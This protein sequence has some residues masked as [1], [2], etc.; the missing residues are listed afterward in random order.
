MKRH[1]RVPVCALGAALLALAA[2]PSP[3]SAC[4][5]FFCQALPM[6]Q[7]GENILFSVEDDGSMTAYVQILYQGEAD[8]FA[9]I[10]PLPSVPELSVGTDVLFTQ[11]GY[12]TAPRFTVDYRTTGTC[13]AEPSCPGTGWADAGFAVVDASARDGGGGG[14]VIDFEGTVGPYDA[15]VLSGGTADE[16]YTWLVDHE[17]QIPETSRP[18]IA[19]YVMRGHHFVAIRLAAD[20]TTSE[21]QPL[22]LHYVEASPCVPLELTAIATVPDMPITAYFLADGRAVPSNYSIIEPIFDDPGLWQGTSSYS[23]W[24]TRAVDAVGGQAFITDYAGDVPELSFA[25]PSIDDLVRADATPRDIVSALFSR[26]YT[27]DAQ[28]L[29]ILTRWLPPPAGMDSRG[30]YNC[31]AF[32]SCSPGVD[33]YRPD[34]WDPV[35]LVSDIRTTITQPRLDAEAILARH[36]WVTRL[37]TTISAPEMT[38]DPTFR[39]DPALS[40]VSNV[41]TATQVTECAPEYF[42]WAAPASL[43][44]P[45]GRTLEVREGIPYAGTDAQYCAD[46]GAGLFVPW[47]PIGTLRETSRLRAMGAL[48]PGGGGSSCG[49]SAHAGRASLGLFALALAAVV[50]VSRRRGAQRTGGSI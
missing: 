35:G 21:I 45:S 2:A 19:E 4:G 39:I 15:V 6:N 12:S 38:L 18:L 34:P 40:P 26:G 22:V 28:L 41:H 23:S 43:T 14:V 20:R 46:R 25:L 37:A 30:Y 27:G 29:A 17:Y 16:L 9:W 49:V 7:A 32:G 11:L 24:L 31:L 42:A 48:V 47:A 13:R 3:A 33:D 5:G 8:A 1:T 44:L 36:T 50:L 10:L